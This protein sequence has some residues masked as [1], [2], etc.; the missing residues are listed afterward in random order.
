MLPVYP[1]ES[2]RWRSFLQYIYTETW[3]REAGVVVLGECLGTWCGGVLK[4][5]VY[6]QPGGGVGVAISPNLRD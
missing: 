3:E 2:G 4:H 1:L 5:G 6:K